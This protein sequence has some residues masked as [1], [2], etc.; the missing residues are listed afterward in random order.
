MPFAGL[1]QL[2]SPVLDRLAEL[3]APQRDALRAA[4]GLTDRRPD[5]FLIALAVLNL[6]GE[7]AARAPVLLIVEDAHWLDRSTPM[8]SR[9]SRGGWRRSRWC[10][11]PRSGTV[12]LRRRGCG[13]CSSSG[14]TTMPRPRC[15]TP[16]PGSRPR[17]ARLLN[18]SAG[19]PLAL[20]ELPLAPH[21]ARGTLLRV[22]PADD[23]AGAGVH[24]PRSGLPPATRTLLLV[25]A[26]N[27]GGVAERDA[28]AGEHGGGRGARDRRTAD[29]R[30]GRRAAVPA[31]AH[32]LGDPPGL[33][34]PPASRGT[35]RAG[36]GRR[37]RPP[38]VAPSGRHPRARR[39][40]RGRAR[41][42]AAAAERRGAHDGR[43]HGAARARRAQRRP[44]RRARRLLRAA[45]LAVELGRH[46]VVVRLLREAEPLALGPASARGWPGCA[47]CSRRS[48][49]R[50]RRGRRRWS[51]S[52]TGCAR[53]RHRAGAGLAANVAFRCWWS[54]PDEDAAALVVTAAERMPVAPDHP[55]LIVVLALAAPSSAAAR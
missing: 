10:C 8:C 35:R 7:T 50:A 19:N 34:P 46:D 54:Y 2:L 47:S 22:A 1:H 26:L 17:C 49:G 43:G 29:H 23:P 24:R 32:A 55:Q 38:R 45:E 25:A 30:R 18:E 28:A 11:W 40:H 39:G 27:D 6:L 20:V 14:S 15:W 44:V 48:C 52:P 16:A 3:A 41:W 33:Q 53:G 51:R 31:P 36:G 4:F 9:S 5:L 42:T 13:S 37:A 12:F 21:S